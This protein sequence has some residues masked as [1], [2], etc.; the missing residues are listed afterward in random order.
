MHW[1]HKQIQ[2]RGSKSNRHCSDCGIKIEPALFGFFCAC[3]QWMFPMLLDPRGKKY[4]AS[5]RRKLDDIV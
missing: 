4:R 5:I 2:Y 1:E 3:S